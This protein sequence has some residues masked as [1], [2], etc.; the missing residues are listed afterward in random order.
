MVAEIVSQVELTKGSC[1]KEDEQRQ[2][3]VQ[4]DIPWAGESDM[5]PLTSALLMH[6]GRTPALHILN[7][8]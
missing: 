3:L 4:E 6:M 5:G 8:I 7:C 2:D 1:I